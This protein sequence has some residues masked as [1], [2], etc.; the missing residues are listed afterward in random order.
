MS[1]M[2]VMYTGFK[3]QGNVIKNI[4]FKEPER[5]EVKLYS[6]Y[7]KTDTGVW[8]RQ[9][10]TAFPMNVAFKVWGLMAMENAKLYSIRRVQIQSLSAQ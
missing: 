6:L 9:R 10:T 2:N 5:A 3:V 8:R 7:R 4:P 1:P